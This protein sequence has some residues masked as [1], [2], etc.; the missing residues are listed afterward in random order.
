MRWNLRH[1]LPV[2]K[3]EGWTEDELKMISPAI[4]RAIAA[5]DEGLLECWYAWIEHKSI[6]PCVTKV[7]VVPVLADQYETAMLDREWA[8]RLQRRHADVCK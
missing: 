6:Q 3:E 4:R 7:P 8:K 1:A 5:Q 2:L